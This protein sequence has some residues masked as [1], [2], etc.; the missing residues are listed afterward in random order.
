MCSLVTVT[1]AYITATIATVWTVRLCL[2]CLVGCC[3]T[4]D[5]DDN[6]ISLVT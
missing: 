5:D 1:V 6:V 3:G 4:S 2:Y